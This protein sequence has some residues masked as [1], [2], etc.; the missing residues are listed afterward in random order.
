MP[1]IG[2]EGLPDGDEVLESADRSCAGI[3]IRTWLLSAL[4]AG[5]PDLESC[6]GSEY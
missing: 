3:D 4:P 6:P 5:E 1:F 2:V